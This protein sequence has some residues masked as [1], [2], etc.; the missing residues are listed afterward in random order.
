MKVKNIEHELKHTRKKLG[1]ILVEEDF[2]TEKGLLDALASQKVQDKKLGDVLISME[3]VTDD[4]IA[5]ALS[6]QLSIPFIKLKDAQISEDAIAI[7]S[8]EITKKYTLIPIRLQDNALLVA[9]SNPLEY[10][11][12]QDLRFTTGHPIYIVVAAISDVSAYLEKY[13]PKTDISVN[14]IDTDYKNDQMQVVSKKS[15]KNLQIQDLETQAGFAPVIRFSN[16]VIA[17]AIRLN[18]SDIHIEPH[19]ISAALKNLIVRYR[20]DGIMQEALRTDINIHAPLL[21]RLKIIS[22]MDIAERRVPQDGK[23]QVNFKGKFF[24]L[25][26]STIPTTYG[27]KATIRILNPDTAQIR[28]EDLGFNPVDLHN[29][30][31]AVERTQGIILV[32]GPTG[33]GKSSTL[34]SFL[35]KLNKPEVNIITVEDPVEFDVPGINQVQINTKAGITFAKGLRSILRQDPDIVMLGEIRDRETAEIA[36]QAAQTGHLV[37]ST[38]H[39]NDAPSAITRLM[40]LGIDDFQ[41]SATLVAVIGQRL[42]RKV[43][44]DCKIID[45]PEQNILNRISP[46]LD[47]GE[48]EKPTFYTGGK[49]CNEC[50]DTGYSGRMGLFEILVMTPR[51]KRL[52]K[53]NMSASNLRDQAVKQGFR[54]I[55]EDGIKKAEQG[56]ISLSEVFRVAP[57]DIHED[58]ENDTPNYV[59]QVPSTENKMQPAFTHEVRATFSGNKIKILVAED[60]EL[61]Q[62]I[63]CDIL[64]SHGYQTIS[65]ENGKVALRMIRKKN[66]DIIVTDYIMPQMDGLQL[67]KAIKNQ[68]ATKDIPI[69]MLTSMDELDSEISVM[70]AGADD[71]LPKPIDRR[72]F[73]SRVDSLARRVRKK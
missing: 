32:T 12:V 60:D 52:I 44:E 29:V 39:T 54:S 57:P 6:K 7:V 15:E 47:L 31:E 46:Y 70:K 36:F 51:L 20:V 42:V 8:A 9:M 14:F 4:Q 66:P 22:G 5:E 30:M 65:A 10:D 11:A 26:I 40:N 48:N 34:Y 43:H 17:N 41:I 28:P 62:E 19:K 49:G 50:N 18:A 1:Q 69:L 3:L 33:S 68:E 56:L 27:E 38:L 37:L 59:E 53:P 21:S 23:A 13:Y 55:T 35:N 25:R 61:N 72:R 63:I 71:Y 24:D 73:L 67:I 45:K 64:E 58:E 16:S 2:L